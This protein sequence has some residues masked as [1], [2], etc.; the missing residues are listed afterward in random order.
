MLEFIAEILSLFSTIALDIQEFFFRSKR[1][2]RRKLEE[3]KG[4]PRKKM[5]SPYDRVVI[6]GGYAV[7]LWIVV[8]MSLRF[9]HFGN[10]KNDTEKKVV[11]IKQLLEKEKKFSGSYPDQ[12]E[13]IKRGNPMRKDLCNDG[14]GTIFK[15]KTLENSY[16]LISAGEDKEFNTND[17]LEFN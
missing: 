15:Y 8:S 12:L 1:E 2:K 3:E 9:F 14:W 7:L 4:L 13:I 5:I 16:I 11:K 6:L 17:D 10:E